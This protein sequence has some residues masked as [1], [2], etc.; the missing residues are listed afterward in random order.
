MYV[1]LLLM[2]VV[3]VVVAA[4]AVPGVAYYMWVKARFAAS[5]HNCHWSIATTVA[6]L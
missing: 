2:Q 1:E 6:I 3:V 4:A 5:A